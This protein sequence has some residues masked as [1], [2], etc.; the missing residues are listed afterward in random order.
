MRAPPTTVYHPLRTNLLRVAGLCRLR[1]PPAAVPRSPAC[2]RYRAHAGPFKTLRRRRRATPHRCCNVSASAPQSCAATSYIS[3]EPRPSPTF[4]SYHLARKFGR[5]AV[6]PVPVS[7]EPS[8]QLRAPTIY[9]RIYKYTCIYI[10]YMHVYI[11]VH[12]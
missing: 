2:P 6:Q 11:S 5:T 9:A 10:Q 8:E 4:I 3:T 7:L 12:K 1:P